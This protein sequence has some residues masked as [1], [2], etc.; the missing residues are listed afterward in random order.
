LI[1]SS[2]GQI[3]IYQF[4][5]V[6]TDECDSFEV[7]LQYSKKDNYFQE[8]HILAVTEGDGACDL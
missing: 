3:G 6:H 4:V 2:P 7:E 8:Y 1:S 5:L